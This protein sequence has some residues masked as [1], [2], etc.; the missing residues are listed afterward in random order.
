MVGLAEAKLAID[1]IKGALDIAKTI[2]DVRD[3]AVIAAKVS[4]LT[5]LML[6]AQAHATAA[7]ARETDLAQRVRELEAQVASFE[8]WETEKERYE[9]Q[10]VG[11]GIFAYRLKESEHAVE[12]AHYICPKC[13]EDR[14]KMVFQFT[15]TYDAGPV[16][17]C[18]ECDLKM[19][20]PIE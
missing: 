12:P 16:H 17:K 8:K 1:G 11:G 4:D 20:L 18:P 2:K 7:Y 13:Y 14:K 10:R 6:D 15:Q 3:E 9:F 5:A 19:V